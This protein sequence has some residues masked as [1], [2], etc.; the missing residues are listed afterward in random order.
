[1]YDIKQF[2]PALYLVVLLGFTGFCVAAE[3]PGL[4]VFSLLLVFTNAYLIK[5]K[6]FRPLPRLLANAITLIF[7]AYAFIEVRD[8]VGSP[9]LTVGQFL[10]LLQLVKI[11]EQRANRDFAQLLILSLLLMVSAAISTAS[12]GFGIL[13][14]CYL[15]LSLYCCLLFHLKVESDEAKAAL[16]PEISRW[17]EGPLR[18][19]QT[20]LA[21]S[22]RRFTGLV[23]TYALLSAVIVFLIFPRNTGAGIFGQFQWKPKDTKTGFSEQVSFQSV[24]RIGQS[25]EVMGTVKVYLDGDVS[26]SRDALLLRGATHDHYSGQDTADH[27]AY[28][29]THTDKST[30]MTPDENGAGLWVP[31]ENVIAPMHQPELPPARPR[32]RQEIE[33]NPTGTQVLFALAGPISVKLD[34]TGSLRHFALKYSSPDQTL[35]STE[36]LIQPIRYTVESTGSLGRMATQ[37]HE[38]SQIDPRIAEFARRPEVTGGL[39][40]QRLALAP[41]NADPSQ[42]Y[43][44]PVDAALASNMERYLR[45]NYRYTLDLT[46]SDIIRTG[47]PLVGFLLDFKKGHCEYF[48]GAM[49]LLCQSLGMDARLVVGFKCDDY[50][51]YGH[52]YTIRQSQAHAWV[53]VRTAD[54]WKSFDPTSGNA[55]HAKSLSLWSRSKRMFDFLEYTWQNSIISYGAENRDNL[56]QSAENRLTQTASNSTKTWNN[57]KDWVSGTSDS[58]A[59]WLVGPMVGLLSLGILGAVAWFVFERWKLRRRARRIG[60]VDLPAS[61]QAKLIRQ[62]GF[63]DDLLQLLERHRI[64]R[65]DHLTPLE[66]CDSLAFLPGHVYDTVFRMTRLFYRIRYGQRELDTGQLRR[67]ATVI[68]RL[69]RQ[70]PYS[71]GVRIEDRG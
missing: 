5:Q 40:Q 16:G 58:L 54:G 59:S 44:T 27:G 26:P 10:V 2:R 3:S 68:D 19:D 34:E 11:W 33:L 23:A 43:V 51:D 6:Q 69:G 28:Q 14:I 42:P 31:A 1:M 9:I 64:T 4:W 36:T 55:E 47:D 70:M 66:F 39:A 67:L 8:R 49:T 52:F 30:E 22:M 32:F 25:D 46:D 57:F 61:K 35:R 48:A 50:N 65:P 71:G 15:F 18:Q 63:Y 37:D 60:I 21:R 38:P 56:V 41:Q 45:Q 24:A 12:L 17:G 13:F 62:L 20:N 53:E 7:F 29:W